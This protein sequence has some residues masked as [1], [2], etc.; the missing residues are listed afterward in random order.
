MRP[1]GV[2]SAA[3]L[4]FFRARAIDGVERVAG[5]LYCRTVRLNGE[6]GTV[7]IGLTDEV[8]PGILRM[9]EDETYS[10]VV[11]PIRL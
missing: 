4:A 10:Y 9:Q 6:T 11:M 8:S 2:A 5:D 3:M 1:A 7:E